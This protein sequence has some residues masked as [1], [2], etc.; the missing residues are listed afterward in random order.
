MTESNKYDRTTAVTPGSEFRRV[1]GSA[2]A[3]L[4]EYYAH[5]INA[6]AD[7][8]PLAMAAWSRILDLRF[9]V[10]SGIL[11]VFA[12]VRGSIV[13]W[14]P[15]IGARLTLGALERGFWWLRLLNGSVERVVIKYAWDDYPLWRV[16]EEH[17][18]CQISRQGTEYL[19]STEEIAALSGGRFR[20][21]RYQR[22]RFIR[23]YNAVVSPYLPRM[24]DQCLELLELWANEKRARIADEHLHK[25]D[26]ES[27]AC[28]H[29]LRSRLPISG[30]VALT[31]DRI[32]GFSVGSASHDGVFNCIF[33]KTD[34]SMDGS[35]PCVFSGLAMACRGVCSRINAGEDWSIPYLAEAKRSWHPIAIRHTYSINRY[36]DRCER[37]K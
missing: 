12:N 19:Y 11:Y 14:G 16:I 15:P 24:M 9:M 3:T 32:I 2:V 13:L 26:I 8:S 22:D 10:E 20:K 18:K 33:E 30:V 34:P 23:S 4:E 5:V 7:L 36:F 37:P 21:K 25:L 31:K 35:E 17:P 27:E 6:P 29:A 1:D 28:A